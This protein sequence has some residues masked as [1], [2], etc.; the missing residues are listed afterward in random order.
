M[1]QNTVWHSEYA[2]ED[3]IKIYRDPNSKKYFIVDWMLH[4][5]CTYDCSYCPPANKSGTD[6]WLDLTILDQFCDSLE[7]HVARVDPGAK[8]RVIFTGGEPTVWKGFATLI[9]QLVD[10]GWELSMS[11]NASRS[12]RWWEENANKF[13]KIYM[14]Y[15]T[16]GVDDTEFMEKVLICEK[17]TE[18]LVNIML[19]PAPVYF[20]KAVAFGERIKNE[21][22]WVSVTYN[23]IQHTFGLQT[24][25]V[26]LYTTEQK[27][28]IKT[29]VDHYPITAER[30]RSTLNNYL[31]ETADNRVMVLN[32]ASLINHDRANFNGWMCSVGLE[33]IFI[34]ARGDVVRG[35]CRVGKKMG[36]VQDPAH[37]Q[38]VTEA[39]ECP[40]SWCGCVTDIRNTKTKRI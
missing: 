17:Q 10:R 35:T 30:Y 37:I 36:N 22:E 7:E 34:D 38:W 16:E 40:M 18:T 13:L 28:K 26:P 19:N 11:T 32:P 15:H 23:Q 31:L 1:T 2:G 25:N 3:I 8:I 21:T 20:D 39:T 9:S 33:S 29:L 24:I 14:S 5:R 12:A 6:S 27:A 4:D